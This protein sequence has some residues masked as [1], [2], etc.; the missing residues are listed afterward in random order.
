L[1]GLGGNRYSLR[2]VLNACANLASDENRVYPFKRMI[3]EFDVEKYLSINPP[4]YE[5]EFARLKLQQNINQGVFISYEA[6]MRSAQDF[7]DIQIG[8]VVK[9]ISKDSHDGTI[10]YNDE[11]NFGIDAILTGIN[12]NSESRTITYIFGKA[13]IKYTDIMKIQARRNT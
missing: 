6:N 8:E 12:Q 7:K 2:L 5:D 10:N 1:G 3:E 11:R 4:L 13:R 9:I